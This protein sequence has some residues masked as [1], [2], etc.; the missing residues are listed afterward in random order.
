M[1][2]YFNP[3]SSF[4]RNQIFQIAIRLGIKRIRIIGYSYLFQKKP[5]L[6]IQ[7]DNSVLNGYSWHFDTFNK[8]SNEKSNLA[9][10]N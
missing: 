2:G 6:N 5:E 7:P 8:G 4:N 10:P 3:T 1:K 9:K